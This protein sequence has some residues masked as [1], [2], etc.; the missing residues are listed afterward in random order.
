MSSVRQ[1]PK[2]Q[3]WAHVYRIPATSPINGDIKHQ[4]GSSTATSLPN[5]SPTTEAPNVAVAVNGST[6]LAGAGPV[7]RWRK[8]VNRR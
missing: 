2:E 1:T 4:G 3:E 8:E 7:S 6:A 5:T